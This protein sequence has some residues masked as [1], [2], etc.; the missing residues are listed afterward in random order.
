MTNKP[1]LASILF[2]SIDEETR[3]LLGEEKAQ[4]IREGINKRLENNNLQPIRWKND[5]VKQIR[6]KQINQE[7]KDILELAEQIEKTEQPEVRG[8][9]VEAIQ[10]RVEMI[11]GYI[12][13]L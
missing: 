10:F 4:K 12:E 2:N 3:E 8:M 7:L 11:K 5:K 13:K 6:L 9:Q 1:D